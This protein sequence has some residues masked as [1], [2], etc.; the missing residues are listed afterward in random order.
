[1]TTACASGTNKYFWCAAKFVAWLCEELKILF[2]LERQAQ[3][4]IHP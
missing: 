1:M 4:E 2:E 3:R